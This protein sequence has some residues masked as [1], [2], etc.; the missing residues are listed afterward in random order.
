MNPA[1]AGTTMILRHRS[2]SLPDYPRERRATA[3]VRRRPQSRSNLEA[4]AELDDTGRVTQH[5][6][7][8]PTLT[9]TLER[10]YASFR[11]PVGAPPRG[12][13]SPNP[14]DFQ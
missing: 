11:C 13:S 1:G 5:S 7:Q 14:K 3:I 8:H 2:N 9:V 4:T 12:V 10:C 6:D